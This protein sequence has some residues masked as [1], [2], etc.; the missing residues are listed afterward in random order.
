MV[1]G[2]SKV[3]SQNRREK[4]GKNNILS[5]REKD[6]LKAFVK[7]LHVKNITSYDRYYKYVKS[8]LEYLTSLDIDYT[9]M[10]PHVIDDYRAFLL[11]QNAGCARGTV[12][13]RLT[14]IKSFY[15]FLIKKQIIVYNPFAQYK[16]LRRGTIIPKNILSIED[17]GKLLDNFSARTDLDVMMYSMVE[18]LYGSSLRI[19][20]VSNIKMEDIDFD[21]GYV[22][23]INFK[24]N[25]ERLRFPLSEVSIKAIKK[26]IKYY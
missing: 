9:T 15:Q 12:N 22:Y 18:L 14:R 6:I 26:Y 11:S 16:G 24:N 2:V 10:K 19:S 1:K 17:M 8:F 3:S 13:N 7:H 23:I 4:E 5:V 21:G 25:E 20:E